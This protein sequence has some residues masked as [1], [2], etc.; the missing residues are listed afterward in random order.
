M[1]HEPR[2][3][4]TLL[5]KLPGANVDGQHYMPHIT[6]YD[7]DAPISEAGDYCQPGIGGRC[8]YEARH[9]EPGAGGAAQERVWGH[10]QGGVLCGLVASQTAASQ[11]AA[12]PP[13]LGPPQALRALIA[14]HT[15]RQLPEPPPR[16]AIKARTH[17]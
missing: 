4:P 14:E 5:V 7:Y 11:I 13:S 2:R 9:W 17:Q 1:E 12:L 6:S 10:V 3:H 8:K 16:P 15:G